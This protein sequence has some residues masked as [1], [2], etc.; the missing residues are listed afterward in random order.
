MDGDGP[1]RRIGPKP[2]V[3]KGGDGIRQKDVLVL[4]EEKLQILAFSKPEAPHPPPPKAV[5]SPFSCKKVMLS[6]FL[7]M[8][9]LPTSE[10]LGPWCAGGKGAYLGKSS[11]LPCGLQTL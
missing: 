10:S 8:A 9:P 4:T 1:H 11:L 2:E 6:G 3:S 7:S 5:S